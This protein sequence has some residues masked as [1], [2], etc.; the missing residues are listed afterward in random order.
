MVTDVD[1]LRAGSRS[2]ALLPT[3]DPDR[4]QAAYDAL[5]EP[6]ACDTTRGMRGKLD[7]L[8]DLAAVGVECLLLSGPAALRAPRLLVQPFSAWPAGQPVTR[9]VRRESAEGGGSLQDEPGR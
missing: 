5:W 6:E 1:G 3:V 7:A 2:A 4:P 8:L 9:I